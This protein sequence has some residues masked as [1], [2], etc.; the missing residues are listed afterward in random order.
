MNTLQPQIDFLSFYPQFFK[1]QFSFRIS[2]AICFSSC[3][4]KKIGCT[5]LM[6][7]IGAPLQAVKMHR[8]CG[9]R[10]RCRWRALTNH[11]IKTPRGVSVNAQQVEPQELLWKIKVLKGIKRKESRCLKMMGTKIVSIFS[12]GAKLTISYSSPLK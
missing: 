9:E 2:Y 8:D 12:F 7:N 4:L 3:G 5:V 10:G 11:P 6:H 1:A